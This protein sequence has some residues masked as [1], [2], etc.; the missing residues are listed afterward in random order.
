[1]TSVDEEVPAVTQRVRMVRLSELEMPL[2]FRGTCG[3][4]GLSLG[5]PRRNHWA[6]SRVASVQATH[7]SYGGDIASEDEKMRE[8]RQLSPDVFLDF[9]QYLMTFFLGG[10]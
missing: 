5:A 10:R 9:A 1:M 7:R 3:E 6:F 8:I 4:L 2:T